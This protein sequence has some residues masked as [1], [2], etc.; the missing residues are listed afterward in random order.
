MQT[1]PVAAADP[2]PREPALGRLATM[3]FVPAAAIV[4]AT[5]VIERFVRAHATLATLDNVHWTVSYLAGALL[6]WLGVRHSRPAERSARRWI[7]LGLSAYAVGQVLWDIQV[8]SGWN[9]FPGPSDTFFLLLGP[10][11]G[12][13]LAQML[14]SR[15]SRVERRAAALDVTGL[16][17][18]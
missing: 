16:S 8:A 2:A 10:L 13:G 14:R 15:T 17:V 7:A 3:I 9:P 18:A 4:L 11:C 1:H 6:A 12:V 5:V